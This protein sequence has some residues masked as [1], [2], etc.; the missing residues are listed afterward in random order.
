MTQILAPQP[1]KQRT[2]AVAAVAQ[3]GESGIHGGV[4]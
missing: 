3:R 4:L 2:G 1:G